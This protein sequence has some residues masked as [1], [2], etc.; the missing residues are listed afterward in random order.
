[1]N[2]GLFSMLSYI[3]FSI[4]LVST[5]VAIILFFRFRIIAVID[6]LTGRKAEREIEAYRQHSNLQRKKSSN[7][8][9]RS[10]KRTGR[11]GTGNTSEMSNGKH[12]KGE[13][14][15]QLSGKTERADV[16]A[17][18]LLRE[19][20]EKKRTEGT[21]LLDEG[22]TSVLDESGTSVLEQPGT[23]LLDEQNF[24]ITEMYRVIMNEVVVHT[25]ERI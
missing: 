8:I 19:E 16:D 24:G 7:A 13:I 20:V 10:E 9:K 3:A 14:T 22:G 25:M 5:V 11:I 15:A 6:D 23:V 4:A 17:T 18:N 1:M 2:E 12:E 21:M